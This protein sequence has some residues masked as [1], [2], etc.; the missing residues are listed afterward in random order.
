LHS[1]QC[2]NKMVLFP[3]VTEDCTQQLFL[4]DL[5]FRLYQWF[6]EMFF[7]LITGVTGLLCAL[8]LFWMIYVI[9]VLPCRKT[10]ALSQESCCMRSCLYSFSTFEM[11]GIGT[12]CVRVHPSASRVDRRF[13]SSAFG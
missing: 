6:H 9:G 13:N 1:L 11:S 4:F 5:L 10:P 3:G 8:L 2:P 7:N 12:L